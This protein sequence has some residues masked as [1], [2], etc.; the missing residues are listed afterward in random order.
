MP[1]RRKELKTSLRNLYVRRRVPG[2]LVFPDLARLDAVRADLQA[3]GKTVAS[4]ASEL[5]IP[6]S[7]VY[8]VLAGQKRCLRGDAHR[9]AVLLGL[10]DGVIE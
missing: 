10:K 7:T 6:A 8:A 4:V 5:Q 9:A 1:T 3:R 2:E